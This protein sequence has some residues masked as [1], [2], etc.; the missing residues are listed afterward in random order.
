M[1]LSPR[2]RS[3]ALATLVVAVLLV[4]DRFV[5]TPALARFDEIKRQKA[6]LAME[7]QAMEDL[8][9]RRDAMQLRWRTML[10][11]GL[12]A[13][14]SA[15]E[16]SVFH[17]LEKWSSESGVRL[18]S[19]TPQRSTTDKGLQEIAFTVAGKGDVQA[20]GQLL[21]L[22]EQAAMPVKINSLQLGS[23][24]ASG[25]E[26]SLTLKLS[27]LHLAAPKQAGN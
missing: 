3:I 4:A 19:V 15:A 20:V 25:Q 9:A 23:T 27:V 7:V 14:P 16:S 11:A 2:E 1:V 6:A 12:A 18:P 24:N 8:L 10:D 5:A 13:D 17:A 26:L 22:I 21:W